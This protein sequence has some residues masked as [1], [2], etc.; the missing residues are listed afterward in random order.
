MPAH[1]RVVQAVQAAIVASA[2]FA[3]FQHVAAATAACA[4]LGKLTSGRWRAAAR[5]LA[6]LEHE[7]E[8]ALDNA[9]EAVT[10]RAKEIGVPEERLWSVGDAA[11]TLEMLRESA[12][13]QLDDDDE[14]GERVLAG[15]VLFGVA[16]VEDDEES[17]RGV[18]M[19]FGWPEPLAAARWPWQ[20]NW[21]VSGSPEGAE[22]E[23][24][25]LF[26]AGELQGDEPIVAE[27]ADELGCSRHDARD[28]LRHAAMALTRASLLLGAGDQDDDG[29]DDDGDNEADGTA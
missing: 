6:S 19:L 5:E 24:L 27:L 11:G 8:T 1:P 18:T 9:A 25:D 13:E 7:L 22:E 21:L 2:H 16:F 4:R 3:A 10:S 20:A 26:E 14:R 28:A 17:D 15:T 29:D 12:L 23:E